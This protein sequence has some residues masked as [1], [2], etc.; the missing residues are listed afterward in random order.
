[1][2][3]VPLTTP[4]WKDVSFCEMSTN[5]AGMTRPATASSSEEECTR[6]AGPLNRWP[7]WNRSPPA[8]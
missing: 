5:V 4:R 3:T 6:A 8:R 2:A 7:L 1:M